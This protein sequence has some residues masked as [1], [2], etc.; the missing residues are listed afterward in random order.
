M[1]EISNDFYLI[2]S[3]KERH[4]PYFK[5]SFLVISLVILTGS[6]LFGGMKYEVSTGPASEITGVEKITILPPEFKEDMIVEVLGFGKT[7]KNI[8]DFLTWLGGKGKD[9][10]ITE[11]WEELQ[12][13]FKRGF[14]DGMSDLL[15][16]KLGFRV[17]SNGPSFRP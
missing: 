14:E 9:W 13:A 1:T 12:A 3:A 7:K 16:K 11:S 8:T 4:M 10:D 15:K 6:L 17:L 5:R 2:K